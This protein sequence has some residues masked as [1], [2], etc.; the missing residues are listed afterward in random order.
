MH[1]FANTNINLS[2]ESF[3]TGV[4]HQIIMTDELNNKR[5]AR[6]SSNS[7][8]CIGFAFNPLL[9]QMLGVETLENIANIANKNYMVIFPDDKSESSSRVN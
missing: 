3:H 8:N 9:I 5:R 6:I 2:A 4:T 1:L 7:D